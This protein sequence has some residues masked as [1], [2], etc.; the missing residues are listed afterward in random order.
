MADVQYSTCVLALNKQMTENKFSVLF[1]FGDLHVSTWSNE[2]DNF[3]CIIFIYLINT[4]HWVYADKNKL[5]L[6]IVIHLL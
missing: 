1:Y 3:S 4:L 2:M 6:N 5:I